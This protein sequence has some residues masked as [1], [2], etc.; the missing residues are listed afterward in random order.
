MRVEDTKQDVQRVVR[1]AQRT[2]R[3]QQ[4]TLKPGLGFERGALHAGFLPLMRD[5]VIAAAFRSASAPQVVDVQ[6]EGSRSIRDPSSGRTTLARH[7]EVLPARR[8]E[9]HSGVVARG[10]IR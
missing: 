5:G 9:R 4:V 6:A 2:P 3:Y 1:A 10:T 7:V 8:R